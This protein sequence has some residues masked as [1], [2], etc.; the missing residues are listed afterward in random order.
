MKQE[1]TETEFNPFL[2]AHVTVYNPKYLV[3]DMNRKN[4]KGVL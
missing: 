3:E 4:L 2:K 1:I